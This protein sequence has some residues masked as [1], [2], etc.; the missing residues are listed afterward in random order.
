MGW[1]EA[2]DLVERSILTAISSRKVTQDIARFMGVKPLTTSEYTNELINI[3]HT[4]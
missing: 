4:L 3:I 2:A 1:T